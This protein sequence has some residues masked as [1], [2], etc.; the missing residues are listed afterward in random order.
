MV[1][2]LISLIF[3]SSATVPF[4]AAAMLELLAECRRNNERDNITGMLLYHGG[5]FVQAI[6][7][8]ADAVDNCFARVTKDQRH[9]GIRSTRLP[10]K[11][12][13]FQNWSMGCLD[14][15][16]LSKEDQQVLNNFLL[17]KTAN[18]H[19]AELSVAWSLLKS[20][21]HGAQNS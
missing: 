21:R 14:G 8:P 13:E 9:F 11:V 7:G 10:I 12:R 16:L 19:H 20:F 1:N 5:N 15:S 4:G 2:G 17:R 3:F 18:E 6:E